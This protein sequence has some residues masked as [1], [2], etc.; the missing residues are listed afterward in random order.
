MKDQ[1]WQGQYYPSFTCLVRAVLS[2]PSNAIAPLV[3]AAS[4]GLVLG[5]LALPA[6][7]QTQDC[8]SIQDRDARLACFDSQSAPVRKKPQ[9]IVPRSEGGRSEAPATPPIVVDPKVFDR[10]LAGE[11]QERVVAAIETVL[12]SSDPEEFQ[13]ERGIDGLSAKRKFHHRE[14]VGGTYG[15]DVWDFKI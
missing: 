7:A 2:T 9:T 15:V 6:Q 4:V 8:R 14:A 10:A 13:F 11:N 5:T 12:E 3:H 1:V